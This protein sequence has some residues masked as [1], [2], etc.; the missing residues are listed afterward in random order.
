MAIAVTIVKLVSNAGQTWWKMVNDCPHA[1]WMQQALTQARLAEEKGEV[2][3]GAVLV[4]DDKMIGE[5]HN[6]VITH[7][8]PSAHAEIMALR[9]AGVRQNNYRLPGSTLYVTLEPCLMCAGSLIHA[10]IQTLVFAAHD[11]KTGVVETVDQAFDRPYHNH[12][13]TV[14]GG[15]LANEAAQ[16]LRDFFAN[17]RTRK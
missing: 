13:I 6:A 2:P 3:V 9:D 10:R 16:I 14:V 8:D 4:R 17:R 15:V 7:S 1:Y 5:G 11:P 12:R